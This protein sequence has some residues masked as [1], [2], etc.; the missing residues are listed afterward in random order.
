MSN[1]VNVKRALTPRDA[2][3]I[4]KFSLK[5]RA[6]RQYLDLPIYSM[7][8]LR[9]IA[10]QAALKLNRK[11]DFIKVYLE[12]AAKDLKRGGSGMFEKAWSQADVVLKN[13]FES[14]K[15]DTS[16]R[17]DSEQKQDILGAIQGQIMRLDLLR[18]SHF[19]Q[20]ERRLGNVESLKRKS[21][22]AELKREGFKQM[23]MLLSTAYLK[24]LLQP[25]KAKIA[26]SEQVI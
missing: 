18:A 19:E 25:T 4:R 11:A 20:R 15:D 22:L 13:L 2:R 21:Q 17:V 12:E 23:Q 16:S 5:L 10:A 24:N 3:K 8:K 26:A 6:L 7:S 1:L 9:I 14:V